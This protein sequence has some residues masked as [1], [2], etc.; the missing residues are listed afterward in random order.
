MLF[1]QAC[2]AFIAVTGF[3]WIGFD[4]FERG[5]SKRS[6]RSKRKLPDISGNFTKK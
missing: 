3:G 4:N 2:L 1:T 5:R 6:G